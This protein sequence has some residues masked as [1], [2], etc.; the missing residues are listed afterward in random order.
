AAIAVTVFLAPNQVVTGGITGIAIVLNSF[1]QTPVGLVVLL[2]N[3]PLLLVGAR[4]LGGFAFGVRTLYVIVVQSFAID[5]LRPI[6]PSITAEPLLYSFYGGLLEGIGYGLIFRARATSGGVDIIA[7]LLEQ[8]FGTPPGRSLLVMDALVFSLAFVVYGPEKSLY[9]LLV[10]FVATT[11]VDY[12]LAAGVRARQALIVTSQPEAVTG[13]ILRELRRGVTL[14]E[15]YGGYTGASRAVLL[16][17]VSRSEVSTLKTIIGDLDP[18]A[19]IIIGEAS[20]VLGEGFRSVSTKQAPAP[21][22][23]PPTVSLPGVVLASP[24]PPT[25]GDNHLLEEL[26]ERQP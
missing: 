16:C 10:A 5:L 26:L 15:G 9:A 24:Q 1:Y 20:E 8:R 18:A 7:R 19:F 3:I 23:V 17:V 13:E 14:L 12:T 25:T 11:A 6:A 21:P 4:R 2:C 22:T